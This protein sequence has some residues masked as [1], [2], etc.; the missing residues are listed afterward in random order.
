MVKL[1][2]SWYRAVAARSAVPQALLVGGG[3][4]VPD[5]LTSISNLWEVNTGRCAMPGPRCG[6]MRTEVFISLIWIAGSRRY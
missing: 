3:I 1:S 5:V 2:A 6:T 4:R